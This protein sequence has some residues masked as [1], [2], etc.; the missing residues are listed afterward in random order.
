VETYGRKQ[1]VSR[2]ANDRL[3]NVLWGFE[4]EEGAF[5]CE[6]KD[7]CEVRVLMTPPEYVRM[8]DRHELVHAPGHD[9]GIDLG[10]VPAR[11]GI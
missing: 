11:G 7:S 5:L 10:I 4:V 1:S 2:T 8:C 3:Y 9:G 6:C